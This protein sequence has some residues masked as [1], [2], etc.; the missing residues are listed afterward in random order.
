MHAQRFD[1]AEQQTACQCAAHAAESTERDDDQGRHGV[2]L[3]HRRR[4]GVA[5]RKQTPGHAR[6][7]QAHAEHQRVQPLGVDAHERRARWRLHQRAHAFAVKRGAQDDDECGADGEC[8]RQQ[9]KFVGGE[10]RAADFDGLSHEVIA[11]Q[12]AAPHQLGKVLHQEH[13]A[14]ADHQAARFKDIEV[15]A[16]AREPR[17]EEEVN[18]QPEQHKQRKRQRQHEQR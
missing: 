2:G 17:E 12:L 9:Q 4:D 16:R 7:P 6:Q 10:L 14:K 3:A 15:W 13:E 1:D 5:H 18:R 8:Q 11:T